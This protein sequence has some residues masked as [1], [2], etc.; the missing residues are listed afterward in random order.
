VSRHLGDFFP[1]Y[2]QDLLKNALIV[3][4]FLLC[5]DAVLRPPDTLRP[6]R[7]QPLAVLVEVHQRE[8]AHSR[9]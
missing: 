2:A 5:L 6:Q 8:A 7:G 3:R 9:L 4:S 1:T